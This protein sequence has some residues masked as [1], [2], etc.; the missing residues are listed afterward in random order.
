M[1]IQV[2]ADIERSG[3]GYGLNISNHSPS[4]ERFRQAAPSSNISI[5]GMNIRLSVI[6][7]NL[8][9]GHGRK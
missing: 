3:S 1:P 6:K 8:S 4:M 7:S 5:K 9:H 2:G